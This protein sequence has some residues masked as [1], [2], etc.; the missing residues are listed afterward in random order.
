MVQFAILSIVFKTME[1]YVI[2]ALDSCVLGITSFDLWT[3]K[4][5][6]DTFAIVI[7]LINS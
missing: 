5:G 2:L 4:F 7:N 6:H 3:F 1:Q